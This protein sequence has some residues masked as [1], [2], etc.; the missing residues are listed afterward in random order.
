METNSGVFPK[1]SHSQNEV[2]GSWYP[3]KKILHNIKEKIL[4][5]PKLEN[6][7]NIHALTPAKETTSS[8]PMTSHPLPDNRIE[9]HDHPK[10]LVHED[11]VLQTQD[12]DGNIGHSTSN[13]AGESSSTLTV[14]IA[15]SEVTDMRN[16]SP[17]CELQI[18]TTAQG[19]KSGSHFHASEADASE[20][21]KVDLTRKCYSESMVQLNAVTDSLQ[22]EL[23][24]RHMQPKESVSKACETSDR[25]LVSNSK[26]FSHFRHD[27]LN[28]KG[29]GEQQENRT[30]PC[31]LS[32]NSSVEMSTQSTLSDTSQKVSRLAEIF[33][34]LTDDAAVAEAKNG[35]MECEESLSNK[36][37]SYGKD[38]NSQAKSLLSTDV[39]L[40]SE[41]I[42]VWQ[43]HRVNKP[44]SGVYEN[45]R[46]RK[47]MIA[48][49]LKEN[50]TPSMAESFTGSNNLKGLDDMKGN[51]KRVH[52]FIEH[53]EKPMLKGKTKRS[54]LK[55]LIEYI[56][57]LPGEPSIARPSEKI[58]CKTDDNEKRKL[59]SK[60][61]ATL[62][63]FDKKERYISADCCAVHGKIK[64]DDS[65]KAL[66]VGLRTQGDETSRPDYNKP[67]GHAQ[68]AVL[69]DKK[70]L[71]DTQQKFFIMEEP[72]QNIAVVKFLLKTTQKNDIVAAFQQ[73]GDIL[74]VEILSTKN[75][76]YRIANIYF[77]VSVH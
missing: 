15:A 25:S 53:T 9:L 18:P 5:T 47:E 66:P 54:E 64:D 27:K 37:L 68:I 49:S 8:A 23:D 71:N 42:A 75:S 74:K 46:P 33:K 24:S 36:L 56:K 31:G 19:T 10:T 77:K 2:G 48:S 44:V 35:N 12:K 41:S 70:E 59:E 34:K 55:D 72:N 65:I 3:V 14:D 45:Q 11:Q 51:T 1:A 73:C 29:F 32:P 21:V 16:F 52:S 4:G 50:V 6:P 57:G 58:S 28:F 38:R 40:P 22:L 26:K 43:D 39:L 67:R 62:Q 76:F 60:S 13:E 63:S 61:L 17:S 7:N 30:M 20:N 69:S